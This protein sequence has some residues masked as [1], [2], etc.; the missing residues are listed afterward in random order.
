VQASFYQRSVDYSGGWAPWRSFASKAYMVDESGRRY[1]PATGESSSASG[2]TAEPGTVRTG[3]VVFY[4][5]GTIAN[6]KRFV[7]VASIGE[8]SVTLP[9]S[10]P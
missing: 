2:N 6:P 1:S 8:G 7:F 4:T 3:T 9:V 5:S 10:V